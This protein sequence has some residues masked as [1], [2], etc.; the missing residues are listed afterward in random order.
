MS[1]PRRAFSTQ[2]DN[3][4]VAAVFT[5]ADL[6]QVRQWLENNASPAKAAR[7]FKRLQPYVIPNDNGLT[8]AQRAVV[9]ALPLK[10]ARDRMPPQMRQR[11]RNLVEWGRADAAWFRQN[12][13]WA[14]DNDNRIPWAQIDSFFGGE[15][16]DD[17]NP[18]EWEA[19]R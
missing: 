7:W 16:R 19:E 10:Q 18:D 2:P 5:L 15:L 12:A 8:G 14:L 3:P 6:Q 17:E 11:L 4:L 9:I 13:P 1:R